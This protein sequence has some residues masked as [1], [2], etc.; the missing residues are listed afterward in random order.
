[1]EEEMSGKDA[2]ICIYEILEIFEII[3]DFESL[4]QDQSNPVT[5]VYTSMGALSVHSLC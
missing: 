3:E 4:P 5:V 2:A 1:M